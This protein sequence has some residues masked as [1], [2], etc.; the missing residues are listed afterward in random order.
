[1]HDGKRMVRYG[2]ANDSAALSK[3]LKSS[4]LIGITP[5]T[6]S[7]Y[8]VGRLLGIFTSIEV[9]RPGWKYRGTER[10]Q[11]Q[12][13]WLQLIISLGGIGRFSTGE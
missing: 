2:L 11:A 6:V 9:K 4:D 12:H 13:A 3:C 1:M 8:D 7:A 10:E 5:H